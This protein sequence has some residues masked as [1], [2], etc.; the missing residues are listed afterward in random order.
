MLVATQSIAAGG[1]SQQAQFE[2]YLGDPN[3]SQ[4]ALSYAKIL[5]A[6]E[7]G[8]ITKEAE[9]CLDKWHLNHYFVPQELGGKLSRFDTMVEVLR[10]V[11]RRDFT[12]GL[13]YG[14]T[15]FIAA[16]NVWLSGNQ[17]QKQHL[18]D[19]LLNNEKVSVVFHELNHGNDF[20]H[21]E[22]KAIPTANGFRLSG[23]KQVINNIERAR[24]FVLFAQTS[25]KAGSR[26][27]SL[28]LIDKKDLSP[29]SYR[30]LPRYKTLGVKGCQIAGIEFQDTFANQESLLGKAGSGVENALKAFQITRCILPAMSVGV[31][32]TALRT[33]LKFAT[34]RKLYNR[35]VADIPHARWTLVN[36]F[37][38]LLIIDCLSGSMTRALHVI[39]EQMSV[40]SALMKYF[41]PLTIEQMLN[42]LSIILGARFYL[43]EGEFGIFQKLLRDYPVVSFGHAGTAICQATIIPQLKFLARKGWSK[44]LEKREHLREI[45]Q[46]EGNLAPFQPEKLKLT[47]NGKDDILGS[48]RSLLANASYPIT[49]ELRSFIV[50]FNS[51]LDNLIEE[52]DLL[53]RNTGNNLC[54]PKAFDLVEKY[55]IIFAAASCINTYLEN[56]HHSEPFFQSGKW[57]NAA[58]QRLAQKLSPNM[59]VEST[60]LEEELLYQM[61]ER[62]DNG[63]S[64][65]LA[66]SP[67][68]G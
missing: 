13:G 36:A 62:L 2:Q 24:A 63:Y 56:P 29:E 58:L 52:V 19:I 55:A 21:N 42:D 23:K 4:V 5:E 35:S 37:L 67:L 65:T 49:D 48:L 14:V 32:D 3:D 57:L 1:K 26:S 54:E 6:D 31:A 40:Y 60:E 50:F 47:N 27:H 33:V 8:V 12:L 20:I 28:F 16:V 44:P 68:A 39:P 41:V 61:C 11:F 17:E 10:P 7:A 46:F 34:K 59:V 51:Q 15:S 53:E 25:E 30:Y 64:F 38:D 9:E 22:L 45:Y 66:G 43:R 18:A